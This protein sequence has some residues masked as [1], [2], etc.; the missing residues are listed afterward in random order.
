MR[1]PINIL[2]SAF[3]EFKSNLKIYHWS[4][5]RYS[6]HIASNNI[7]TSISELI[8]NFIETFIGIYGTRPNMDYNEYHIN[9]N[10]WNDYEIINV[11]ENFKQFLIKLPFDEID[12]DLITLRDSLMNE[13]NRTL[14]LFTL[15]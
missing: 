1:I 8:D 11:F 5:S 14:Y 9:L 7:E 3:M 13:L 6:R 15:E 2:V 4:T 12:V 10:S